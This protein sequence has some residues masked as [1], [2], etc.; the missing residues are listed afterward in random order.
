LHAKQRIIFLCKFQVIIGENNHVKKTLSLVAFLALVSVLV[1]AAEIPADKD[2]LTFD[3]KMG[4]VTFK[5]ASHASRIGDCVTCHHKTEG[6]AVPQLCSE[7]HMPKEVKDEAP[8]LKDAVHQNCQGCHQE[9]ADAGE[10][11]G[12]LKKKCKECHIKEK[13]AE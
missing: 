3:A 12:P 11:T 9:K 4:T 2:V 1:M 10:A 8:K 7:C 5:H 13:A 6:D